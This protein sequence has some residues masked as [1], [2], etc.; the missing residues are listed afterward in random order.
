M[1]WGT[2]GVAAA[3]ALFGIAATVITDVFRSRREKHQRWLDAKQVAYA[4]FLTALAQT[5]SRM[6]LAAARGEVGPARR[7]AIRNTRTL[8]L[9][10]V[11]LL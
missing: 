2:L 8:S 4:R 3:G 1:E 10:C 7:Q 6:T 5:H 11:K 9:C